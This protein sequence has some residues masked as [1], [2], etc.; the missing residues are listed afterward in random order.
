VVDRLVLTNLESVWKIHE[1]P[2]EDEPEEMAKAAEYGGKMPREVTSLL[3]SYRSPFAAVKLP[4]LIDKSS[5]MQ[6]ASPAFETARL[7]NIVG[8][9]TDAVRLFA[10][11]LMAI[12][13]TGFFVALFNAVNERAYDIALMRSLGATRRKIV[14]FVLVEGLLLGLMGALL[15]LV[16]GHGFSFGVESWIEQSRHMSLPH[17]G[18]RPYEGLVV[19]IALGISAVAAVVP[20]VIAYRVDVPQVLSEGI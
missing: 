1:L 13:A 2:D 12:A 15:G 14:G 3:I 7:L 18:L 8:F 9:G 4:R 11:V 5:S 16:L 20:S 19:L 6:A 17:V 10:A